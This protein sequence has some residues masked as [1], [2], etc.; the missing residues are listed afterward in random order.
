MDYAIACFCLALIG[1]VWAMTLD[2]VNFERAETISNATKQN[3]NL[4]I[5]LE[6]QTLRTLKSVDQVALFIQDQYLDDGLKLDLPGIMKGG[7]VDASIVI[8]I[9][10]IDALGDLR[11]SSVAFKP[12]NAKDREFFRFH[13]QQNNNQLFV[14]KPDLGRVTGK[15]TIHMARRINK[16]DGSFGGV[17]LVGVD[18]N[19][20]TNFYQQTDLGERGLVSLIGFDGITRAS[21]AGRIDSYEQDD[22][23]RIVLAEQAKSSAGSFASRG[24]TAGVPRFISYRAMQQYPLIVMVG[25]SQAETLASFHQR[26]RN[27]YLV[28]AAASLFGLLFAAGLM[29]A[30]AQH[31]RVQATLRESEERFRATFEQAAVGIVHTTLDRRYLLV[32]QKFCDMLGY[33]REELLAMRSNE[34]AHPDERELSAD[35][36]RALAG[37][38]NTYAAEKRYIRKDGSILWVNRTVSL[39][40]DRDGKPLYFIRVIEDI[41][42]RKQAEER[43]Q[44]LATYDTLTGLPNRNTFRDRLTVAIARAR[45]GGQMAALMFLDLD[46]FKEIND[47]LGHATGDKVLQATARLLGATLRDVDTISRLGGDEFTVLLEN[48]IE[49]RQVKT[50]AEKIEEAFSGPIVTHEGRDIFVTT[51]IGIALYPLDA[52]NLDALLHA[53]D[54]AMYRAKQKGRN[55]YEFYASELETPADRRLSL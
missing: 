45:R 30:L 33:T 43:I 37:E 25:T 42:K 11:L 52:D 51:S 14:G 29:A 39:A 17:V 50:I 18:P 53:A 15:W 40:R 22:R 34:I 3:A 36:K 26:E 5:A 54:V 16:P 46:R 2:R 24:E 21:R 35:L 4:A 47:T 55:T 7:M 1:I 9:N 28:A 41:G 44:Y 38:I 49:V 20:F 12:T 19:Y 6:E 48:I 32:N 23:N 13:Q 8:S 27:Y 10:I 31:K